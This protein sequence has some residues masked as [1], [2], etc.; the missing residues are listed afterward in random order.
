M[1]DETIMFENART[2][3]ANDATRTYRSNL[4]STAA[5][6][7]IRCYEA[8]GWD[9]LAENDPILREYEYDETAAAM[10]IAGIALKE[11]KSIESDFHTR[12]LRQGRITKR[13]PKTTSEILNL[14]SLCK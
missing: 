10:R 5:L 13:I 8:V 7:A 1:F 3:I 12:I 2:I 4:F 11:A 14:R 6:E 9:T